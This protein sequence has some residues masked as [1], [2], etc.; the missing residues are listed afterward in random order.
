[1]AIMEVKGVSKAIMHDGKAVEILKNVTFHVNKH[2]FLT[3][4]GPSGCGKSTLL[5]MMEGLDRP[6][7]GEMLFHGKPLDGPNPKIS[8]IFQTFAL[9]PW[10]SALE[11]VE[12]A[13]EAIIASEEKRRE[14][15]LKYIDLVGLS[16]FKDLYP[17]ELS[18]GMKQRVGIA[19]ALAVE[20]EVLLMDEPFSSLDALTAETLR[21]EV[22]RI[23]RARKLY[24]E[25]VV[26]VTHNVQEAVFMSDRVL[27]MSARPGSIVGEIKVEIPR[28]REEHERHSEFFELSDKIL[29]IIREH[30][31]STAKTGHG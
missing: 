6:T 9:L 30:S 1:M 27:V 11:N 15:A 13:L 20:P 3:I 29:S 17:R 23:W 14:V 26:M 16:D 7:A 5:R 28:P 19:R 25:S 21:R 18:G 2:E 10:K 8:I 12:V 22:L 4:V 31:Q 24:P